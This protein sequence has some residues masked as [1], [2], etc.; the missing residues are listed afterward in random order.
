MSLFDFI[1]GFVLWANLPVPVFW[2]VLHTRVEFWR[3]HMR[4]GYAAAIV[5]GWGSATAV[6]WPYGRQLLNSQAVPQPVRW[7]GVLLILFDGWVIAHVERQMG[8]HRLIGKAELAGAGEMKRDGLYARVRHPRYAA[9]MVST[10]GACLMAARPAL[11]C[12]ATVW[13]AVVLLMIRVEERELL[14]R[15]GPDYAEYRRR[16]PALV[17]RWGGGTSGRGTEAGGEGTG[18]SY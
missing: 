14:A 4:A 15:F 1:A 12:G 8:V 6:A 17:P 16:V 9:M 5:A 10:L 11:W 13:A 3:R 2:L 18:R 7:A